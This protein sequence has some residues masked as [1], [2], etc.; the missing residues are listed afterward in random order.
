MT[1]T[2]DTSQTR[3]RYTIDMNERESDRFQRLCDRLDIPC[4]Q[5]VREAVVRA[6]LSAEKKLKCSRRT[7]VK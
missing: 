4:Q 6:I 7:G 5:F 2:T 1:T 3:Y